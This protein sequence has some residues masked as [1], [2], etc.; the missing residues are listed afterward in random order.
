M[1]YLGVKNVKICVNG[2][3][4]IA[5]T[6]CLPS[7]LSVQI[8]FPFFTSILITNSNAMISNVIKFKGQLRK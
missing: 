7:F 4:L 6:V 5:D 2:E 1:T 8:Y 3:H